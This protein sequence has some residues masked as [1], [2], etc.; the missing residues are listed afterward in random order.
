M[1]KQNRIAKQKYRLKQKK[2]F[3]LNNYFYTTKLNSQIIMMNDQKFKIP[4]LQE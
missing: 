3:L 2:Y 4:K 1:N